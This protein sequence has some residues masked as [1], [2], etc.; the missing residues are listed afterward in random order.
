MS[1][2]A[3]PRVTGRR[4]P[5]RVTAVMRA[6]E[7][8]LG[9]R[10][11]TV[12]PLGAAD[13]PL[14]LDEVR[15]EAVRGA[16]L[17]RRRARVRALHAQALERAG[18]RVRARVARRAARRL[19]QAQ[20]LV[21]VVSTARCDAAAIRPRAVA[22]DD[23]E[24]GRRAPA[25][26]AG[27]VLLAV[28]EPRELDAAVRERAAVDG[29]DR[30]V[31]GGRG[32]GQPADV[33]VVGVQRRRLGARASCRAR[34]APPGPRWPARAR[35]RAP[36]S[37][38]CRRSTARANAF[39]GG[40]PRSRSV[41]R[42]KSSKLRSSMC[43]AQSPRSLRARELRRDR[44]PEQRG[45]R[46]PELLALVPALEAE[47]GVPVQVAGVRPVAAS[48][49]ST[50]ACTTLRAPRVQRRHAR[51][52]APGGRRPGSRRRCSRTRRCRGCTCGSPRTPAGSGSGS[53][54]RGW[55]SPR[56]P[57]GAAR[58][59][60]SAAAGAAAARG[61]RPSGRRRPRPPRTCGRTS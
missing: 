54:G 44:D 45:L 41:Q 16:D 51:R 29:H 56:P 3:M 55:R 31:V 47:P 6:P 24:G 7:P 38:R 34:R 2:S 57:S 35:R 25:D 1:L 36:A 48:T 40:R 4:S 39:A 50:Q 61:A 33:R 49:R 22:D 58:R 8:Q 42:S 15:L 37:P 17:D 19:E 18:V 28:E 30:R 46:E 59:R 43:L 32:D 12:L 27:D 11:S 23:P 14:G 10:T 53:W 52:R 5:A 21:V 13:A 20:R 60:R 26:A 9:N